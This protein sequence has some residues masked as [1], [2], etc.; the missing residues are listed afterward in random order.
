MI[1]KWLG[2]FNPKHVTTLQFSDFIHKMLLMYSFNVTWPVYHYKSNNLLKIFEEI[3]YTLLYSI[4]LKGTTLK[5]RLRN[6]KLLS[7]MLT[8][9]YRHFVTFKEVTTLCSGSKEVSTITISDWCLGYGSFVHLQTFFDN[10]TKSVP[11]V[12]YLNV[13]GTKML[14]II[15]WKNEHW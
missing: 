11:C 7:F 15:S 2:W 5:K 8:L 14:A 9:N 13:K 10:G 6:P 4:L 3:N 1:K 12:G